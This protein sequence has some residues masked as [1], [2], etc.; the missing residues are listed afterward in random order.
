MEEYVAKKGFA[1]M[2]ELCRMFSI[3][4]NTARAD[5]R[6]LVRLGRAQKAYGGVSCEQVVNYSGYEIQKNGNASEK[7]AIAKAA[8]Q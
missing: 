8:A 5:V 4:I 2:E 1:S 6:D 3:S 7:A